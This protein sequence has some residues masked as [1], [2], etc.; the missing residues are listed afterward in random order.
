MAE[1]EFFMMNPRPIINLSLLIAVF[2][3]YTLVFSSCSKGT[4]GE[5]VNGIS[6]VK[7]IATFKLSGVVVPGATK[8][9]TISVASIGAVTISKDVMLSTV[10]AGV[11]MDANGILPASMITSS[12]IAVT[13]DSV[14]YNGITVTNK[15]LIV[16]HGDL[17][18][19]TK[20]YGNLAYATITFGDGSSPMITTVRIP[21]FLYYKAVEPSGSI[22][23][24]HA[25][26]VF[27]IGPGSNNGSKYIVSPLTY[28]PVTGN[29]ISG[30]KLS[31]VNFNVNSSQGA[32]LLTVGLLPADLE[33]A[34][35]FNLH[36]LSTVSGGGYANY[37]TGTIVYNTTTFTGQM[38]FSTGYTSASII[39]DTRFTGAT[40]TTLSA[41]GTVRIVTNNGFNY[42]YMVSSSANAT[43]IENPTN[44]GETR[45]IFGIDF[46]T[47]NEFLVDYTDHQIGL[48]NN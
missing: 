8:K 38:A 7:P 34:T 28:L 10:G 22:L 27:G 45:S 14:I 47:Q 44:S 41:S 48:K 23:A 31:M 5:A 29:Q 12:G 1:P 25:A 39:Q 2:F 35:G 43:I 6:T 9:L 4:A 13:G 36:P 33:P 20:L 46:F 42:Q 11:E 17:L 32:C 26:D 37:I 3:C 18:N 19:S 24:A 30:F 15:T 21:F 16:T 40:Y